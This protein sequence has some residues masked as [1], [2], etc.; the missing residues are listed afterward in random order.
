M[1]GDAPFLWGNHRL[2]DWIDAGAPK[3]RDE[4]LELGMDGL[5]IGWNGKALRVLVPVLPSAPRRRKNNGGMDH[6]GIIRQL[7]GNFL[8]QITMSHHVNCITRYL[9]RD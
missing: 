6:E 9:E 1:H 7:E 5:L 3:I 2:R 4:S 8:D